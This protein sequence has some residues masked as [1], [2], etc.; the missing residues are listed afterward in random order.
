MAIE[1]TDELIQLR[2]AADEARAR[3][4]A[5]PYSAAAWR[6]WMEAAEAVQVA[7]TEHAAAT[8]QNRFE[9]EKA[10]VTAAK[11]SPAA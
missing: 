7:V 6:P 5:G 10:L 1:L 9:V 8:G 2:R 3:A 11:A 4:T